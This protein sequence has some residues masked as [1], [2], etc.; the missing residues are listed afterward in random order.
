MNFC[1]KRW[2][3][4]CFLFYS[5]IIFPSMQ[6]YELWSIWYA[7]AYRTLNRFARYL[8][9]FCK[10]LEIIQK[11][12]ERTNVRTHIQNAVRSM[13]CVLVYWKWK[14]RQLLNFVLNIWASTN[15]DIACIR[16]T[17]YI[18]GLDRAIISMIRIRICVRWTLSTEMDGK[19]QMNSKERERDKQPY[20][21]NAKQSITQPNVRCL[22]TTSFHVRSQGIYST[23][24]FTTITCEPRFS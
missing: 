5:T 3:G 21:L 20:T 16:N 4:W 24:T 8:N 1:E 9:A 13:E 18:R 10:Q 12:F 2:F 19:K 23:R 6:R 17:Q 15:T 22:M 11:A 14:K 7:V